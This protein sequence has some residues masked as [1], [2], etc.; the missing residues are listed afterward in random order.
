[1][2]EVLSNAG[3]GVRFYELARRVRQDMGE[4]VPMA[5]VRAALHDLLSDG[6]AERVIHGTYCAGLM[7]APGDAAP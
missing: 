3:E 4:R 6:S 7:V 2:H 1:M 5:T